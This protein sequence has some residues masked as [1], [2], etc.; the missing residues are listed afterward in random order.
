MSERLWDC[1]LSLLLLM[2]DPVLINAHTRAKLDFRLSFL[3]HPSYNDKKTIV[4]ILFFNNFIYLL[5][6]MSSII[7]VLWIKICY[8]DKAGHDLFACLWSTSFNAVAA[9]DVSFLKTVCSANSAQIDS[10]CYK[11]YTVLERVE[12]MSSSSSHYCHDGSDC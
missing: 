3:T 5:Q 9:D 10:D 6:I 4:S 8:T 11:H 7:N 2:V 1:D 12:L